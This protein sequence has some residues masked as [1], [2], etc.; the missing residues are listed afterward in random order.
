MR[1]YFTGAGG[2]KHVLSFMLTVKQTFKHL[3]LVECALMQPF[4]GNKSKDI[5]GLGDA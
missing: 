5:S 3:K 1:S 4:V 2:Q